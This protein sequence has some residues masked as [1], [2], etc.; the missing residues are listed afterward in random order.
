MA[1]LTAQ[2]ARRLASERRALIGTGDDERD[3]IYEVE[4]LHYEEQAQSLEAEA[5][6]NAPVTITI[7]GQQVDGVIDALHALAES[8]REKSVIASRASRNAPIGAFDE[9]DRQYENANIHRGNATRLGEL[10]SI[11]RKA[12]GRSPSESVDGA[13]I[14]R[15]WYRG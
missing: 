10:E 7:T 15:G 3:F 13:V 5:A 1:D 11:I 4:A 6:R 9:R 2:E 12:S 8:E 14:A